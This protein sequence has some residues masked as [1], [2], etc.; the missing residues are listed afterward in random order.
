M[1][2]RIETREV[3]SLAQLVS[4]DLSNNSLDDVGVRLPSEHHRILISNYNVVMLIV[5]Q[6]LSCLPLLEELSVR[7]NKLRKVSDLS[8]CKKVII[9]FIK[10]SYSFANCHSNQYMYSVSLFQLQEV[11]FSYNQLTDLTGLRNLPLLTVS[12]IHIP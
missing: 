12:T 8:R 4:L 6:C 1:L 11:D 5:L 3:V 10:E 7:A 2:T 9:A